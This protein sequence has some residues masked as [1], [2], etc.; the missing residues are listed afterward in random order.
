MRYVHA[1]GA[2]AQTGVLNFKAG[3]FGTYVINKQP[4]S[5]QIWLS[6]PSRYVAWLIGCS[7]PKRFDY[8]ADQDVWFTYKNG[9]LYL[10]HALLDAEFS[11]LFR[12]A[13]TVDLHGDT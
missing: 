8:D 10:L 12:R 1:L 11:A 3:T 6:S 7:G 13:L 9:Q 4:P 2:N 5:R